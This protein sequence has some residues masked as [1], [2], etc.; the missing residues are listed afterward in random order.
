MSVSN[1]VEA[2]ETRVAAVTNFTALPYVYNIQK[3]NWQMVKDAYGVRPNSAS[4]ADSV[5]KRLTYIQSFDVVLTKGYVQSSVN[6]EALRDAVK[7]LED[8]MHSVFVDLEQTRVGIPS[9][10]LNVT[11]FSIEEPEVF[12]EEKVIA[13]TGQVSILYRFSV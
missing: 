4:E 7:E 3:N 8:L 12:D 9:V 1:I 10:V 6:D 11:N 13:L 5:S 2:I